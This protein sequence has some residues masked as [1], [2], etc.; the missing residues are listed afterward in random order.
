LCKKASFSGKSFRS[1]VYFEEELKL[2][3]NEEKS[4]IGSPLHLKFLGFS[5][6]KGKNGTRIR[7]HAKSL[8]RFKSKLK[9]I[10]RRNR[11]VSVETVL[12]NLKSCVHG[13]LGYYAPS[14]YCGA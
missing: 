8:K 4:S 12:N 13:W 9:H 5:L 14:S 6:Y 1:R 2:K 10:T 7:I 11:G 3:V